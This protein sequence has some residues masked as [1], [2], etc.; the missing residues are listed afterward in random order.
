MKLDES[1]LDDLFDSA[2]RAFPNTRKRQHAVDPVIISNIRYTPFL[3]MKTLMVRSNA[4]NESREYRPMIVFKQIRYVEENM[5]GTLTIINE[6]V[7]Y[8][9]IPPVVSEHDVL[10]RCNCPDFHWRFTHFNHLDRSLFGRNRRKYEAKYNPGSA[11]P[12][13]MPG[14]CKHLMALM[15]KL[16]NQG[17]LR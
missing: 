3:R 13:E 7:P 17:V 10:L 12:M 5:P 15:R 16:A 2:V 8:S 1:S 6:G 9:L 14:M 11:N 4:R